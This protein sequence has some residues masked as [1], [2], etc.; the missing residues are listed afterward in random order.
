MQLTSSRVSLLIQI[1]FMSSLQPMNMPS[2]PQIQRRRQRLH[3]SLSCEESCPPFTK[4]ASFFKIP[5][6][7]TSTSSYF[8]FISTNSNSL[9]SSSSNTTTKQTTKNCHSHFEN[10]KCRHQNQQ[11]QQ[12]R[13]NQES[14]LLLPSLIK[15]IIAI[16]IIILLLPTTFD[17]RSVK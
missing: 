17:S 15:F 11:Q 6:L 7:S 13:Q 1:P 16:I 2:R 14:L 12:R 4:C 8:S 3:S 5:F 9:S 10:Q